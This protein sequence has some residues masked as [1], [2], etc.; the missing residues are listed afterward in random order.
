MWLIAMKRGF[1][2]SLRLPVKDWRDLL[3]VV[4]I[5]R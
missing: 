3:N 4:C 2:P 1:L 5:V